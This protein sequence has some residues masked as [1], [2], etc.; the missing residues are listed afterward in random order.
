M[1]D[2]LTPA[3]RR[4]FLLTGGALLGG[5]MLN[6]SHAAEVQDRGGM[7]INSQNL[8]HDTTPGQCVMRESFGPD[9]SYPFEAGDR[10]IQWFYDMRSQISVMTDNG[11]APSRGPHRMAIVHV[12]ATARI[13]LG[14][15]GGQPGPLEGLEW[16]LEPVSLAFVAERRG[17]RI[18]IEGP[19][20]PLTGE[21]LGMKVGLD[22]KVEEIVDGKAVDWGNSRMH[23]PLHGVSVAFDA[24]EPDFSKFDLEAPFQALEKRMKLEQGSI[25]RSTPAGSN[26][27]MHPI[28]FFAV[29]R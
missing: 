17:D 15:K 28:R 18:E 16:A 23:D 21:R 1:N 12:L 24:L 25:R 5:S 3:N 9:S 6:R 19:A 27:G 10:E 13:Y 22:F 20:G 8:D 29:D 4:A 14:E 7:F 2:P 26:N 11:R